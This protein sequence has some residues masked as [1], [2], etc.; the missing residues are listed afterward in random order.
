MFIQKSDK[1]THQNSSW[2]AAS[3]Q[4]TFQVNKQ[5]QTVGSATYQADNKT[6]LAVG[7]SVSLKVSRAYFGLI[8]FPKNRKQTAHG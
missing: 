8:S 5:L 3:L 2:V 7:K 4:F 6:K 1:A